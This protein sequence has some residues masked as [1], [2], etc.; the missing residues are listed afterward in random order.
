MK[1]TISV[2][3]P[4]LARRPERKASIE[5]QFAGR[6][7]F[8][9]E[10]VPA[11][12][13]DNPTWGL[14][15][16]F[17][18]I[19]ER[20]AAQGSPFFI[21]CEDDHVFTD[22]YSAENLQERIEEADRLGADLLSGGMSWMRAPVQVS[23]HLFHVDA[24][25]GMQF[26]V[27]FSRF[28]DTILSYRTEKGYVTDKFLSEITDKV[29]VM[30]PNI[31]TQTDFGY[32]DVTSLN[33]EAGRVPTL[34]R[35]MR[36]RLTTLDKAR[37]FYLTARNYLAVNTENKDRDSARQDR[38]SFSY[39]RDSFP[40]NRD[41]KNGNGGNTSREAD[42]VVL[43]TFVIHLPEHTERLAHVEREFADRKE[44]D[45]HIVS[46]CRHRR[47]AT[48]L[49][50][51]IRKI[52][53]Q[54]DRNREDVILVCEDDHT[55][56]ANYDGDRFL[57]QVRE[58]GIM[59]TH[60]LLGGIGGFGDMAPVCDGLWWADWTWCTQFTVI[61]RRAFPLILAAGFGRKD[62]ADEFL[63]RLLANKLVV[64]P[65]VSEQTDF[66]Y[67]DVTTSNNRNGQIT[68]HFANSR[69][70]AELLL[71]AVLEYH[72]APRMH[73]DGEMERIAAYLRRS[74]PHGLHLGCGPNPIDGWLNTDVRP[75]GQ[76]VRLDAA[77]P[78][79]LPDESFDYAFSE[80]MFE[81]L[82]YEEGRSML[83]ECRRILR[84]GGI[85]R[86]TVPTLDFL[87]RLYREPET[88]IHR[89]Y[90]EWHLKRFAPRIYADFAADGRPLPAALVVNDFMRMW[91]HRTIYDLATLCEMLALVGFSQVTV[92]EAGQSAHPFLCGLEHHGTVIPDWANQLE[93]VTVEAT[94]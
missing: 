41:R 39:N 70:R 60:I 26:T 21:F 45:V 74:G 13:C 93:S 58:A 62:V 49:W 22:D 81:H 50:H 63:S 14:W 1:K 5:A 9:F 54:A 51:S 34:F 75:T 2:H 10:V 12:E 46:A 36:R 94:K 17:Y 76:T 56:T 83:R 47:G 35:N 24:F 65:F 67:S 6:D 82:D 16:T 86:L 43:P 87:I 28:Y 91:D 15:Q 57:R 25:N 38:D 66:G 42:S 64:Y 73:P 53:E 61:Y 32:S 27:V 77:R 7:E 90:T 3:A 8:S 31:S 52:V 80:H 88:E 69:R 29:F 37:A 44:F 89:R 40:Q 68:E 19:V 71:R 23:D 4:N 55:F 78:F 30:Y 72:T 85:L 84:P 33:N 92:R 48:G 20:E 79:P 18:G 11:I 59:G